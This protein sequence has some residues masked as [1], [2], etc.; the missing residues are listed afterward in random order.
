[1]KIIAATTDQA[2]IRLFVA[3]DVPV[4]RSDIFSCAYRRAPLVPGTLCEAPRSEFQP[5][6]DSIR[7]GI[8][9]SI[10]GVPGASRLDI[11]EALCDDTVCRRAVDDQLLYS[12]DG[13]LSSDGSRLALTFAMRTDKAF[14]AALRAG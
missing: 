9:A 4:W 12:D 8:D 14:A 3:D 7:Q 10:A 13:H 1:M 5:R 11:H 2:G 6:L